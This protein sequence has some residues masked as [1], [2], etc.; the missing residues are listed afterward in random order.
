MRK[1]FR[2]SNDLEK[3]IEAKHTEKQCVYCEKDF[4]SEEALNKHH[5]VCTKNVG[6]ANSICNKCNQNFTE[7]G[8]KRHYLNCHVYNPKFDCPECGQMCESLK[9]MKTHQNK[10]H[11]Y[12]PVR[13][14]VVCKHWRRGHCF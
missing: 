14:R 2:A 8:L 11:E 12:E 1:N 10:E 3:H 13:S 9:A 5:K 7:N 6:L 4:R